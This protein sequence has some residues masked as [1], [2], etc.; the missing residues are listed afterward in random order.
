MGV[1]Y[2]IGY[3]RMYADVRGFGHQNAPGAQWFSLWQLAGR[4]IGVASPDRTFV[5][6]DLRG[7]PVTRSSSKALAACL[8]TLA[9][10]GFSASAGAATVETDNSDT[11]LK[12]TSTG[13]V[14]D[15]IDVTAT[16][17]A[18]SGEHRY[19]VTDSAGA[20]TADSNC[21]QLNVTQV[22]CGAPDAR[23]SLNADSKVERCSRLS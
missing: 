15:V 6:P 1:D 22:R 7:E 4:E 16:F 17:D 23:Q 10:L 11:R 20:T 3:L 8:T 14:S 13:A 9:F 12:V 2:G 21:A 19:L 18:I 5:R